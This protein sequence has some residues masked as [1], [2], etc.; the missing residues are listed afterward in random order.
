M[1]SS[2]IV[3]VLN[4]W[5]CSVKLIFPYLFLFFLIKSCFRIMIDYYNRVIEYF[6]YICLMRCIN[7]KNFF[8]IINSNEWEAMKYV[9]EALLRMIFQSMKKRFDS[10]S[11]YHL[12]EFLSKMFTFSILLMTWKMESLSQITEF[13]IWTLFILMTQRE[14]WHL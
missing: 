4:M 5:T 3:F 6:I 1:C 12:F 9:N 11:W 10:W 7:K 14:E 8:I 13:S 2:L